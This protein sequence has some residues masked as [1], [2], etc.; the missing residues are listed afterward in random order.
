MGT[1]EIIAIIAAMA[2]M[3]SQRRGINMSLNLY[4]ANSVTINVFPDGDED[5][6][7]DE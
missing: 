6:E 7:D 3:V 1:Q 2:D 5:D 4:G